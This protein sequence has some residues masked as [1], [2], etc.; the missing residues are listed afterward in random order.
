VL[1]F[2]GKDELRKIE[3]FK[4]SRK[5]KATEESARKNAHTDKNE[6]NHPSGR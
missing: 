4:K 3:E 1:S 6:E 5:S 2:I